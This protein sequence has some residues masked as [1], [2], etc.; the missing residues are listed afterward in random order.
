MNSEARLKRLR[1]FHSVV[2][3]VGI[4]ANMIFVFAL[5]F[6]PEWLMSLLHIPPDNSIWV[7]FV[8]NLLLLL[9]IFYLPA[10]WDLQRYRAIAWLAVFPSRAFGTIFF[11]V[12][13]FVF[14]KSLG[15]LVFAADIIF[16]IGQGFLLILITREEKRLGIDIGLCDK[17]S[18]G[19]CKTFCKPWMHALL[20]IFVASSILMGVTLWYKLFRVVDQAEFA[21]T[22]ELFKYGSIGSE[23]TSGLPYWVWLVLPRIFPEYLPAVGAY[24]SLGLSWEQGKPLPV[25]ISKKTVGFPRVTFNCA[26]CHVSRYRLRTNE[27]PTLVPG[28]PAHTV[29]VLA[30]QRFLAK[31]GGDERFNSVRILR[32]IELMYELSL[33]D[34]FLYAA[35]IIPMTKLA[36]IQFGQS[37][38]WMDLP[39]HGNDS[40]P[41]WGR[42]RID[43]FNPVKFGILEINTDNTIGNSGMVPIWNMQARKGYALHWDGL[44]TNLRDVVESSAIGDGM[45]HQ[46]YNDG[47]KQT[48]EKIEDWLLRLPAPKSPYVQG[49]VDPAYNLD[50]D[51]VA[52]GNTVFDAYCANCHAAEGKL[53]G[54]VIP[55]QEVG[56]DRHRLDM[57][58]AESAKR[59]NAYQADYEWGFKGF[60]KTGGY[61]SVLLDGIWLRAPYL[62]N[63]S[64]PNLWELLKKPQERSSVFYRGYD[65]YDA[66]NVGFVSQGEAAEKVGSRHDVSEP[67]N[68]N[69]GHL[70]GTDLAFDDKRA[71]LEYL[72]TL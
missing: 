25:G 28:G 51:M 59:Y 20:V 54:T 27:N 34:K 39:V 43:P 30:Y 6:V 37:F 16:L 3:G 71:L 40:R 58:T 23:N 15:F 66:V 72:K 26:F 68:S 56:T 22:E 36:L 52:A 13:V 14:H 1:F 50:Q 11:T 35:V 21:N 4:A 9:S 33:V 55:L 65:L 2:M 46:S 69:R 62:H 47:T 45:D 57:W 38:S 19:I 29:N 53:T 41:D 32:E 10:V 61:V 17:K 8:A 5:F 42:G 64:V 31:A 48:L 44:N 24:P 67:G 12:A 49:N 70:Y 7:R 60:R 18:Q 63:A